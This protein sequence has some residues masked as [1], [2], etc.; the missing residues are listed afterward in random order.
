LASV[1]WSSGTRSKSSTVNA[2]STAIYA[3]ADTEA[4]S[5]CF[6][7]AR[8]RRPCSI[9][10]QVSSSIDEIFNQCR[11]HSGTRR[12]ALKRQLLGLDAAEDDVAR[13]ILSSARVD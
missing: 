12:Q 9:I 1:I 10:L 5:S 8:I 6:R 13:T 3:G 4:N 2:G 11:M 7:Q